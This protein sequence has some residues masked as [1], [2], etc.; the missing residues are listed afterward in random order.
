MGLIPIP[1]AELT[2]E[3]VAGALGR[4]V[5]LIDLI[6]DVLAEADPL[7]V[8]PRLGCVDLPGTK[9]WDDKDRT[10]RIRWWVRRVGA[11]D[12]VL[13]AFPG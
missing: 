8:R 12:T 3:D 2:D 7:G 4:A 1:K 9:A 5:T 6:L 11:L 13:V 10:A